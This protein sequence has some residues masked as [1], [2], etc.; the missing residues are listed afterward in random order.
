MKDYKGKATEGAERFISNNRKWSASGR[1]A[2]DATET[3]Y[4]L[5]LKLDPDLKEWLSDE[6]WRQRL[7]ITALV[8]DILHEYKRNK[9]EKKHR[10]TENK[11]GGHAADGASNMYYSEISPAQ[12]TADLFMQFMNYADVKLTT[13]QGYAVAIRHFMRWMK[14]SGIIQPAREDIKAYKVHLQTYIN[15]RGKPYSAGT[16][17]RYFRACKLFF[18]WTAAE[19]FYPNIADNIKA[20]KIR[21]DNT[22]RDALS[23]SDMM[24]IL[25]SIDRTTEQ[26]K[27]N[28]ALILLCVTGG[29]RI[30]EAQRADISDIKTIAGE[31]VLFIQGRGRDEKDEYKKLVP[32]V[33]AA[34]M[35]YLNTRGAKVGPLFASTSVRNN[36]QRITEPGISRI[37]KSILVA[38]GYDSDRITAHSLRHTSVTLLLKAGATLQQAQHHA[39]HAD[40]ATTG[41]YAHNIERE[42]DKSEEIIYNRIF[43]HQTA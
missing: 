41:I 12:F 20:A 3:P 18:K 2:S 15:R 1:P 16:Q 4:R 13:T 14:D 36:G 21:Q 22:H 28:Y 32:E 30:I 5:S 34:I 26:G 29:L 23:E 38:A 27:R 35:D 24:R 33:Y 11:N 39:R 6:A 43:N 42:K 17:A 40:P 31:H 9:G 7:S 19:G 37:I 8:N 10:K 25:S